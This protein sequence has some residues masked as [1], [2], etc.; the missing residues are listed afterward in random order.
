MTFEIRGAAELRRALKGM[1]SQLDD[2]SALH[3]EI[4]G[5]VHSA[6]VSQT[7]RDSGTLAGS[8]VPKGTRTKAY[9]RS[10]VIYAPIIHYGWGAR[11][12]SAN[13]YG[14]R[15]RSIVAGTIERMYRDGIG[16]ICDSV[17]T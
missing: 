1:K 4:A 7:P 3:R 11:G 13:P 16:R 9:V 5:T 15:G 6:I 12:I 17:S 10:T 8:L 14:D 2:L